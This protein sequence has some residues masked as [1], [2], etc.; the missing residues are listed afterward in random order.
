MLHLQVSRQEKLEGE[1]ILKDR[2]LEGLLEQLV[3]PQTVW[4]SRGLKRVPLSYT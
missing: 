4:E 3:L 1:Q 2:V